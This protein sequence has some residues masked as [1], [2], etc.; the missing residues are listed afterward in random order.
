MREQDLSATKMEERL[1]WAKNMVEKLVNKKFEEMPIE[2]QVKT[3]EVGISIFIQSERSY[4]MS[5]KQ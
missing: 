3:I 4:S 2:M 5:K 1:H